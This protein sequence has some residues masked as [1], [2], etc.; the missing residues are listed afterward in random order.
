[1]FINALARN[2]NMYHKNQQEDPLYAVARERKRKFQNIVN[3]VKNT[4][5]KR[6]NNGGGMATPY[7]LRSQ[8]PAPITSSKSADGDFHEQQRAMN[9][10]LHAIHNLFRE[11]EWPTVG[12]MNEIAEQCAKESGDK[13]YNH[14]SWGGYWSMDVVMRA[15]KNHGYNIENMV[16]IKKNNDGETCYLWKHQ[17]GT[18]NDLLVDKEV[19]GF[20]I[21]QPQHYTALRKQ[22]DGKD[23][24][25]SNS[26]SIQSNY[27]NPHDFCKQALEGV[28]N[29]YL[30]SKK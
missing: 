25:Y 7:N 18:M 23:W 29:I 12:E 24:Q 26:Y 1:M 9:C 16:D 20:I 15:I 11:S 30:V 8:A 5:Y 28:W 2:N 4:S 21:H 6:N 19:I 14:K 17:L 27:M 13:V 3:G 22:L 10:G